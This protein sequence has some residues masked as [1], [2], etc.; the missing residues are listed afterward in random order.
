MQKAIFEWRNPVIP[1]S[2][3]AVQVTQHFANHFIRFVVVGCNL[4]FIHL[5]LGNTSFGVI[6]GSTHHLYVEMYQKLI[7]HYTPF[8]L[9]PVTLGLLPLKLQFFKYK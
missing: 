4:L 3:D 6:S 8:L 9:L 2:E 1:H 7:K 5:K